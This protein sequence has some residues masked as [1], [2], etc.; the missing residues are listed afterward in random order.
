MY[1][2]IIVGDKLLTLKV[3]QKCFK[4]PNTCCL[5]HLGWKESN[6]NHKY[7]VKFG[8]F[9]FGEQRSKAAYKSRQIFVRACYHLTPTKYYP[10]PNQKLYLY[11]YMAT[12]GVALVRWVILD[13]LSCGVIGSNC[14]TCHIS[15]WLFPYPMG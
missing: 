3:T 6:P 7:L 11:I 1:I 4:I 13:L 15:A 5:L 8:K 14:F 9:W 2:I 10:Q 12:E